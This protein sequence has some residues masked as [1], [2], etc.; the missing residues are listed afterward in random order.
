MPWNLSFQVN[1][2]TKPIAEEKVESEKPEEKGDAVP[3]EVAE[4]NLKNSAADETAV[5]DAKEAEGEAKVAAKVEV[6][7]EA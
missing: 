6:A 3:A 5:T 7:T 2:P 1:G 4:E